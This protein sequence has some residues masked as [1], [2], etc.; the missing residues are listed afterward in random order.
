M[1]HSPYVPHIELLLGALRINRERLGSRAK[2]AVDARLLRALIQALAATLPFDEAFYRATYPDLDAAARSGEIPD[3]HQ[4]FIDSGFIEGRFGAAAAVDEQFYKAA[5]PDVGEAVA[6][7][8]LVSAQEH[9]LR[10]GAG[11]GRVPSEALRP[12]VDAWMAVLRD[13][14]AR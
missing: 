3:L 12:V 7:G 8:E 13:D 2:I 5:Y 6:R 14:T 10:S 1:P 9:Y 11:E 4:H